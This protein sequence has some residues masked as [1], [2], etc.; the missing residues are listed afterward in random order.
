MWRACQAFRM[1]DKKMTP[2]LQ[3]LPETVNQS[4]LSGFVKVDH[5]IAAEDHI[6]RTPHGPLLH[7]IQPGKVHQAA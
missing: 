1:A 5:H 3:Q 6:E 2:W 4:F 7:Q